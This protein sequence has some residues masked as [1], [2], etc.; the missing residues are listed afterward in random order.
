MNAYHWNRERID[1]CLRIYSGRVP[2]KDDKVQFCNEKTRFVVV[3]VE[4]VGIVVVVVEISCCPL[5][6]GG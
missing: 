2:R 1:T 4:V 5:L 6:G 3:V